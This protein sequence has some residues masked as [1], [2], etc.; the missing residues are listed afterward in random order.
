MLLGKKN[1]P[2]FPG[3]IDPVAEVPSLVSSG[4]LSAPA[5]VFGSLAAKP[6]GGQVN[7]EGKALGFLTRW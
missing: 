1:P 3:L 4:H 5:L 2:D 7:Q 6:C